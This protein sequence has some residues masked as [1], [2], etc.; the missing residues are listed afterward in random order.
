MKIIEGMFTFEVNLYKPLGTQLGIDVVLFRSV[1]GSSLIVESV[2]EGGIV[3]AWNQQSQEPLRIRSGDFIV[4]VNGVEG[5]MSALSGVL[6]TGREFRI[7]VQR[8]ANNQARFD[9]GAFGGAGSS[10]QMLMNQQPPQ[11]VQVLMPVPALTTSL[12]HSPTGGCFHHDCEGGAA[13]GALSCGSP[14]PPVMDQAAIEA[15]PPDSAANL[16]GSASNP[17]TCKVVLLRRGEA[18]LGI[19]VLPVTMGEAS[20]LSVKHILKGGVVDKWNQ[21]SRESLNIRPGD[22]II[23]VN[24]ITSDLAPGQMMEELRTQ[25]ELR[26]TV[27]RRR[28]SAGTPV[29][30]QPGAVG[31]TNLAANP[32]GCPGNQVMPPPI[33][34]QTHLAGD[35]VNGM[36]VGGNGAT[37]PGLS[38]FWGGSVP[39]PPAIDTG[40]W[41]MNINIG[42]SSSAVEEG[43]VQA[44]GRGGGYG[45]D[46]G[47]LLLFDVELE[48]RPF[49]RLGI[50]VLLVKGN[51][52]CDL[53]VERV[54][55]GGCVDLW[56]QRSRPPHRVQPGDYVV[57]VNGIGNWKTLARIADAFSRDLQQVRFTV[58]RG[59][60]PMMNAPVPGPMP[61]N[62][63]R[64]AL[65]GPH[66]PVAPIAVPPAPAAPLPRMF[67]G[68][69][70]RGDWQDMP[71]P[72]APPPPPRIT[73]PNTGLGGT[74]PA[75]PKEPYIS[76]ARAPAMP[77]Q[78]AAYEVPEP[79]PPGPPS[80]MPP[81]PQIC[82]HPAMQPPA[83]VTGAST[84]A[85]H[86]PESLDMPM[87]PGPPP[88][89]ERT[90]ASFL[91]PDSEAQACP[92]NEQMHA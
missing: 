73:V 55:Q 52:L 30:A 21:Q 38:Q 71:A 82:T 75:Y 16:T 59:N 86:D 10:Q 50:D 22:C 43:Q 40:T 77:C 80:G 74:S 70:T 42:G 83:N 47:R 2:N 64:P 25:H 3:E 26:L 78:L 36:A 11:P 87:N 58:Q 19:D 5:N 49:M 57:Q 4:K 61:P 85:D 46:G 88:G 81:I 24:D 79:P 41:G 67:Q 37:G 33:E 27:V 92:K 62:R 15:P 63:M 13:P 34:P 18:R 35:A 45:A 84:C 31:P 44:Q 9:P 51:G 65:G 60:E 56:N 91:E 66:A 54:A 69:A 53:V 23:R 12:A 8:V 14:P 90:I 17:F 48:K 89:L 72:A 32:M 20:G 6:R 28:N 76:S 39:T 1:C 7:T 68:A 29:G